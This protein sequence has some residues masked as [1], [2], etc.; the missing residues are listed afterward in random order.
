MGEVSVWTG[1][2]MLEEVEDMSIDGMQLCQWHQEYVDINS[3]PFATMS[4]LAMVEMAGTSS[5]HGPLN[6]P[7]TFGCGIISRLPT[8]LPQLLLVQPR[9]VLPAKG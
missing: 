1:D 4:A 8:D 3:V 5:V 2:M 7:Q 9:P 6:A